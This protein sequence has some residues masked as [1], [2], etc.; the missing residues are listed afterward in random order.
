[1]RGCCDRKVWNRKSLRL[2]HYDYA[3]AGSY[4]ITIVT[5]NRAHLFGEIVE[6]EM[7]L[8]EAGRMVEK[9]YMKLEEKFQNYYEHVVRDDADY[10]RLKPIYKITLSNGK[11]ICFHRRGRPMCLPFL[12][13]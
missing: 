10:V 1:M 6:S 3:Q 12:N 11:R 5:Q 8:N 4:F 9:W 2:K 7:V 13:G